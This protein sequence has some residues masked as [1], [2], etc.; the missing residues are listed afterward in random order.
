MKAVPTIPA[1]LWNRVIDLLLNNRVLGARVSFKGGWRHPWNVIPEYDS[2][3]NV[4]RA[5]IQPGFVNELP[6]TVQLPFG[7][8]PA[9]T[10][11]R[12]AGGKQ[13]PE[14]LVDADLTEGPA[15]P[16]PSFR[17]VGSDDAGSVNESGAFSA[18]RVPAY[19]R[20]LGV[21][22]AQPPLASVGEAGV[23]LALDFRETARLRLLRACDLVL[24]KERA[25]T[26]TEW[27]LGSGIDGTFAQFSVGTV[28]RPGTRKAAYVRAIAKRTPPTLPTN[29][30]FL[31]GTAE[32]NGVDSLH[33]ATVFLL[34]QPG[35]AFGAA[36]DAEWLPFVQHHVFWNV[37]HATNVLRPA[38]AKVQLR[39][40]I[41]LA[42]GFGDS[43]IGTQLA[44]INDKDSVAAEFIGREKMEG[45][46]WT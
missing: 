2:K 10:A 16:L 30:D 43:F 20:A 5:N 14:D 46:F 7:L 40:P 35:A 28:T 12:L 25:A 24:H 33:L 1:Y 26:S 18:E 31:S 6:A 34:S 45:R 42:G 17:P 4:W 15:I 39:L 23:A 38:L 3:R 22:E 21:G 13:K 27:T 32:D 36:P 19:F 9:E 37:H 44:Q 11:A 29:A 8:A 41:G